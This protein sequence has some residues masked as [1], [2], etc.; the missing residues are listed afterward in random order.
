[1]HIVKMNELTKRWKSAPHLCKD[2][3]IVRA[4]ILFHSK[5][6]ETERRVLVLGLVNAGK[7]RLV[8]CFQPGVRP[9]VP[10]PRPRPTLGFSVTSIGMG[11]VDY[12]FF[13][14]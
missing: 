6:G 8:Q 2:A 12:H 3:S 13:Q 10:L 7:T 9:D 11:G 5:G 1:M 4:H 14:G